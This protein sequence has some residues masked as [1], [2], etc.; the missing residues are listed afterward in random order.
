MTMTF[1]TQGKQCLKEGA[2]KFV[3]KFPFTKDEAD[4]GEGMPPKLGETFMRRRKK[5]GCTNHKTPETCLTGGECT[6]WCAGN[7]GSK[8]QQKKG[9][10][11]RGPPF[12]P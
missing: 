7:K 11:D 12:P 3:G 9:T 5:S 1:E 2:K 10:F 4:R 6:V 8:C